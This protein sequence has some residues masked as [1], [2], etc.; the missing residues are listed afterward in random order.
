MPRAAK[1]QTP[2]TLRPTGKAHRLTKA[3]KLLIK[4]EQGNK[5]LVQTSEEYG[6]STRTVS[7]LWNDGRLA[8]QEKELATIKA[9][10]SG[11]LYR[12]AHK[13]I[14]QVNER[15]PE[16]SASQA[17]VIAG[18]MIDKAR[19]I[20]NQSTQNISLN[21]FLNLCNDVDV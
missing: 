10:M 9:S 21:S 4:G 2:V 12:T 11:D 6:V 17:A 8:T 13:S 3:E 15:L 14:K 1:K 20:D 19:L 16:A 5:S 18:I 7:R